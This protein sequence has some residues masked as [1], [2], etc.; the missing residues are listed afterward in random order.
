VADIVTGGARTCAGHVPGKLRQTTEVSHSTSEELLSGIST[1]IP[2]VRPSR[3]VLQR[4]VKFSRIVEGFI[5]IVLL[6][7]QRAL[8]NKGGKGDTNLNVTPPRDTFA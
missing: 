6:S 4:S 3:A 5:V 7:N 8:E 2:G 1:V